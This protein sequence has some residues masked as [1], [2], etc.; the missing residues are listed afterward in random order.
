MSETGEP[1]PRPIGDR[2]RQT[3]GALVAGDSSDAAR[4][5][6]DVFDEGRTEAELKDQA[7]R[8]DAKRDE[9]FKSF[10]AWIRLLAVGVGTLLVVILA[11]I[12]VLH[13]ILPEGQQWLSDDQFDTLSGLFTGVIG[14]IVIAQVRKGLGS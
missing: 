3:E 11:V 7:L 8:G 13:L 6:Q 2:G 5:E 9:Q 14:T 10:L 1:R 12:Y 4:R